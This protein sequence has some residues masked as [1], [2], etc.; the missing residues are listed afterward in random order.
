LEP[1]GFP[2]A[3]IVH[4]SSQSLPSAGLSRIE[5]LNISS[6]RPLPEHS[7]TPQV[8]PNVGR[9]DLTQVMN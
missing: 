5:R 7:Q 3:S 9:T 4:P 2:F 8:Y 6:G 1:W